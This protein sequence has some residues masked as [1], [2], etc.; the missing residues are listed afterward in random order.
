MLVEQ[1]RA[2]HL[3]SAD[4]QPPT[5]DS[6]QRYHEKYRDFLRNVESQM[7][8]VQKQAERLCVEIRFCMELYGGLDVDDSF[9]F[10]GRG[11]THPWAIILT[12]AALIQISG[13]LERS[14]LAIPH[15]APIVLHM[16]EDIDRVTVEVSGS[17]SSVHHLRVNANLHKARRD[18]PGCLHWLASNEH[19]DVATMKR[20][21]GALAHALHRHADSRDTE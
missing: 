1:V 18:E 6:N 20:M 11:Q 3:S 5:P 7:E 21:L 17:L 15:E 10:L 13:P 16:L 19:G 2:E 9:L 12:T 14:T 4:W 8:T